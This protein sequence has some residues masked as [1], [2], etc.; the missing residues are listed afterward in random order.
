VSRDRIVRTLLRLYPPEVAGRLGAELLGTAL[1]AGERSRCAF[2][3]ECAG[4]V[5]AGV[6]ARASI[7]IQGGILRALVD[8]YLLAGQLF[9]AL[10]LSEFVS[11][12]VWHVDRPVG[13]AIV[14]VMA[15]WLVL[16]LSL[17]GLDRLA[18]TF[19]VLWWIVY[20]L[21]F[22]PRFNLYAQLELLLAFSSF[23]LMACLPQRR[24]VEIRRLTWLI[25]VAI[26]CAL[27]PSFGGYF[28][29]ARA[30]CLLILSALGLLIAAV[31]IRLVVA[32]AVVW[33][34]IGIRYLAGGPQPSTSRG[35]AGY[36]PWLVL[37]APLVVLAI[38][39]AS[40]FAKR[41][42]RQTLI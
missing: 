27:P 14:F 20:D 3:R 18:G 21:L 24:R 11:R 7:A 8:G 1:D 38:S 34:I 2:A 35:F 13:P 12:R 42:H 22:L 26:L 17:V 25:P 19:V 33:T 29:G 41:R 6:R 37:A 23:V 10:V 31:N 39:I 32:C 30:D 16:A 15:L 40:S 9:L 28:D 36:Q 4:I 5:I